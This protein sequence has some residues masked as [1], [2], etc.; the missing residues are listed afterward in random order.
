[1]SGPTRYSPFPPPPCTTCGG[2]GLAYAQD[3]TATALLG[4]GDDDIRECFRCGGSGEGRAGE[5]GDRH[6]ER[7]PGVEAAA[8]DPEALVW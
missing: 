1:M 7:A 6:A 8:L 5:G 3:E 4:E 2:S